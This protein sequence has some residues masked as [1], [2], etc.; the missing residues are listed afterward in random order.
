MSAS[1]T[2]EEA[3]AVGG[4][5]TLFVH[6]AVGGVL[7]Q[8][9]LLGGDLA[10][11]RQDGGPHPAGRLG[12]EALGGLGRLAGQGQEILRFGRDDGRG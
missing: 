12:H 10:L 5:A 4:V 2:G 8:L 1:L 3:R 11:V 6:E 7:L 9:H